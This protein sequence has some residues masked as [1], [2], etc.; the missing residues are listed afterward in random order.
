MD[1]KSIYTGS[2]R[3]VARRAR[4]ERLRELGVSGGTGGT[5]VVSSGGSSTTEGDGHTHANKAALDEIATDTERYLY[6]SKQET[7]TDAEGNSWTANVSDKV[8]AG[9]ADEAQ[10][11]AA[12][13]EAAHASEAT[14]AEHATQADEAVHAKEAT[15]AD[16]ARDLDVDSPVNDRYLRKDQEDTTSHLLKML[17]GAEFGDFI[18]SMSAGK[19]AGVDAQGNMQ[20]E[21]L[22]VRS[23]MKVM[24][25]I[26]NRLTAMEGDYT[27]TESG[28]IETVEALEEERTFKV[29]LRKRWDTDFTAFKEHD[30]V[31]GVVNSLLTEG[32]YKTCWLRILS[33]DTAKN[34]AVVVMYPDDETPAGTNAE[35]TAGM[36]LCRRGNALNSDRQSCW[37]L[38]TE[39]GCIMY[40]EGVTKPILEENNYYLTLGRPKHLSYFNGMQINYNHPYLWARGVIVQDVYRVDYQGQPVYEVVDLGLWDAEAQ[41]LK[42][43]SE[44][45]RRY[46]QH[47]V[48][49]GNCCWRCIVVAATVGKEPRWNN[50]E[51]ACVVGDKD[52]TLEIESSKGN[53]FRF[54]QEY[55]TLTA[56]LYHGK[57]DVSEDVTEVV[58][59]RESSQEKED[60]LWNQEH[61]EV[62]MALSV[63][64]KDMPSDWTESRKVTFRC[65]VTL[66][67]EQVTEQWG[68]S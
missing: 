12:A 2:Q 3:R 6:L 5:V 10:Y 62:G 9:Y 22:E 11:A 54:G 52:F 14:E 45:E 32:E 30:V 23:Y 67:N 17:A 7:V 48:W 25:L 41:Y 50:T 40:L 34:T 55:T 64:P 21:S 15:H 46:V 24:E 8:K 60:K 1:K 51:W 58:W 42:A 33:V 28:T 19:G 43:Y 68:L 44:T 36:N 63:T 53:F 4:N 61:A 57:I 26:L 37:Y 35:P 39:E 49:W 59:T 20:V 18:R 56:T 29:C 27:F 65:T 47:Q 38:S 31:Y 13:D 16:T 66:D